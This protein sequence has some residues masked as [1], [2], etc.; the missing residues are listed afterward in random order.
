VK[1][2]CAILAGLTLGSALAQE[3]PV[4]F[5]TQSRLVM[6]PFHAGRGT[7]KVDSLKPSDVVLL[8]DG[9][10]REFT[11]FDTTFGANRLP[12]ELVLLFDANPASG[13]LWDPAG[14]FTFVKQWDNSKSR[15]LLHS[16]DGDVRVSVYR[17]AGQ[18]LYRLTPA[19]SDTDAL[20]K[21]LRGILA[22]VSSKPDPNSVT[23]L[24][25]PPRR[26]RVDTS[27]RFTEDFVTSNFVEAKHRGWM[28]ESAI[29]LLNQMSAS[30]DSVSRVLV[31]F[32]EG[33]G[34]TT[35]IPEDVGDQALD[36]GI[37][38]YPVATNYKGHVTPNFPRN[39]FRMHQF[40]SLGQRTGGR[41]VEYKTIDAA[42]LSK[43]L[44][45][46][47]D[48]AL[49]QY[50]VG[51]VPGANADSKVHDLEVRLASPGSATIEGGKRRAV[52]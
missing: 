1:T 20:T 2:T 32:S 40:E 18:K 47:R 49:S 12:V 37:P 35:T 8:E 3:Q 46:V 52:Y 9:V 24:S 44:G 23:Q 31:M 15:S 38:I 50:V 51:F 4:T 29:G 28:L 39:L 17:C 30:G 27:E 48:H 36:L 25:L 26:D 41:A 33:I 19:T 45:D 22:P 10:A 34:A 11:I 21:A 14:V 42:A 5:R 6:L 43:I 7:Q 16:G 13:H